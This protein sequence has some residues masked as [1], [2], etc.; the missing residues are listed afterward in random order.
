MQA[1]NTL[2]E[3]NT[4]ETKKL[5]ELPEEPLWQKDGR[6]GEGDYE[7]NEEKSTRFDS[8]VFETVYG[9]DEWWCSSERRVHIKV[10][11]ESCHDL[12]RR[13]NHIV[14]GPLYICR[15]SWN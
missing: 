11:V 2:Y 7:D 15:R 4:L 1:F 14:C 9:L 13:T 6:T 8:A 12:G 3:W 5:L 10:A